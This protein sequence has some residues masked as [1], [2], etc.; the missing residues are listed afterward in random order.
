M[1]DAPLSD[2]QRAQVKARI[3]TIRRKERHALTLVLHDA[4]H[5]ASADAFSQDQGVPVFVCDPDV[6]AALI[7]MTAEELA[8][9]IKEMWRELRYCNHQPADE[10]DPDAAHTQK[11]A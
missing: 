8:A 5:Q 4:S 1:V 3:R 10:K 9:E 6:A 2:G 11:S 7:G